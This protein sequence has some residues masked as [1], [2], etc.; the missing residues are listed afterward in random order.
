MENELNHTAPLGETKPAVPIADAVFAWSSLALG[1]VFTHFASGYFGGVWG[2]I[3]W[4]LFGALGAAFAVVKKIAVSPSHIA[5]FAVAELFC[6]VPLFSANYF[7][8]FLAG[9]FS[10]ILYFY[11]TIVISGAELFGRHFVLDLMLSVLARPFE[12]FLCQPKSALSVFRNGSRSKNILYAALG[13]LIALPLTVVVVAL[14]MSSDALFESTIKGFVEKLPR[15]SVSLFREIL[16]AVPISMYLF[17]AY[18]SVKKPAPAYR[19]GAPVY[20]VLPPVLT[21]FAVTPICV[22]YLIYIITQ[23]GNISSALDQTLDYAEFARRGFF[24][25]W[26]ISV[27]NLGVIVLM[28]TFTRRKDGDV[29]PAALRAYTI[30]ISVFSL[31]IIATAMTKMMMYIGEYGMTLMR[32][33]TSWFMILLALTFAVIIVLQVR[34][35]SVWRP[36]FVLFTTMLAVLCFGDMEGI[37]ARHNI[38]AYRSGELSELDIYTLGDLGYSAV[39]PLADLL[40]NTGDGEKILKKHL[41][42]VLETNMSHDEY[43]DKFAYF[44]IPRAK[45]QAALKRV[46]RLMR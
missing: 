40:E 17:G 37:I 33:Y 39:E 22:F 29:R 42:D 3:F 27:I 36:L 12:H 1:F 4:A 7:I 30:A 44:S 24:E 8:N 18:S 32:V 34:D 31:L 2:G 11:L 13:L 41:T 9:A 5:V 10:F 20:R 25:Q 46:G 14:L 38:S 21:Y 43:D 45:A 19:A 26:A 35:F 15:F 23:F 16:F 28:Q 6:F